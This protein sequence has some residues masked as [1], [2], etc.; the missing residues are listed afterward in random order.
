MKKNI[1]I[2]LFFLFLVF[3][4]KQGDTPRYDV[5]VQNCIDSIVK[6]TQPRREGFQEIVSIDKHYY[7][8]KRKEWIYGDSLGKIC[9]MEDLKLMATTHEST[10]LR[11]IAFQL[12]LERSPHDAVKILIN[13][14]NN[15]DSVAARYLDEALV[16]SIT[17]VRVGMVQ[18]NRALYHI[19]AADSIA[20]DS[21]IIHVCNNP[22]SII[23][24]QMKFEDLNRGGKK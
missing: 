21:A 17:S 8:R 14:I 20:L 22:S 10:A 12:L 9:S 3:G 13:D 23:Y 24:Y 2:S 11:V 5:R 1:I 7:G 15:T 6:I 4:C 16:N 18:M 19:S